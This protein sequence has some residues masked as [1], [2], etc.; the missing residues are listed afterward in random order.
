MNG[1]PSDPSA[2]PEPDCPFCQDGGWVH[3]LGEDGKI[4]YRVPVVR[5]KCKA[6]YDDTRHRLW[7]L[8]MCKLPADAGRL[9]FDTWV[10]HDDLKEP[11]EAALAFANG[12]TDVRWLTIMARVDRGKS[13]LAMAICHRYIERGIPARYLFVPSGLDALRAGYS[14]DGPDGYDA[15]LR[16]MMNVDLLILDDLGAQNPTPWAQ[17]KLMMIVEERDMAGLPLVVT[18]NKPLDDLPGDDEHRIGSRLLRHRYGQI[19][20]IKAPEYRLRHK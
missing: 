12:E 19:I 14:A 10:K 18:T 16:H 9:T 4:D 8:K 20:T 3:Q 11:Y 2:E 17:E 7:L 1:A 13:H 15:Q 6:E 5:C